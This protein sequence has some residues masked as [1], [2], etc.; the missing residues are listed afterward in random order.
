MKR[1]T[2]TRCGLSTL[3]LMAITLAAAACQ[4]SAPEAHD[5]PTASLE[6]PTEPQLTPSA[7]GDT[8]VV[9]T[10][11]LPTGSP[12]DVERFVTIPLESA[13]IG[14][15]G[16]ASVTSTSRDG[17]S[18]IEVVFESGVSPED[19]LPRVVERL[20]EAHSA[21][22]DHV[23]SPRVRADDSPR[24]IATIVVAG[25]DDLLTRT[26]RA[27]AVSRAIYT[28]PGVVRVEML[29][30]AEATTEVLLD[31][32]RLAA[33][34]LAPTAVVQR[35]E[36]LTS[37]ALG[38]SQGEPDT[39]DIGALTSLVLDERAVRLGDL[40]EISVTGTPVNATRW[41]GTSVVALD[42]FAR[43]GLP[44]G[45]LIDAIT[46]ATAGQELLPWTDSIPVVLD[47]RAADPA[48]QIEALLE[49][50][51][52][53]PR[54]GRLTVAS[55]P[56]RPGHGE[57]RLWGESPTGQLDLPFHGHRRAASERIVHLG[58]RSTI[59]GT[60][61]TASEQLT[62]LLEA[63]DA[64]SWV[65]TEAQQGA[66]DSQVRLQ[67]SRL[68]VASVPIG[69]AMA[70]LQMMRR[71]VVVGDIRVRVDTET[72]D[73]AQW[74]LSLETRAGEVVQLPLLSVANVQREFSP[75]VLQRVVSMPAVLI[76]VGLA[77][78]DDFGPVRAAIDGA[79]GEVTLPSGTTVEWLP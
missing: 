41:Q 43:P 9:V 17:V 57:V 78:Y 59:R 71:G 36:E 19:A 72:D 18:E 15:A 26:E 70:T 24:P 63:T 33:Y 52:E 28:V 73:L 3:V 7:D 25:D 13:L 20:I 10:T 12:I 69:D 4:K 67:R 64:V 39:T 61:K 11:D 58:V 48:H 32:A 29:G 37:T 49:D 50:S 16:L 68:A 1:D 30:G 40:A 5:E 47:V 74:V 77:E 54:E 46:E 75:A 38:N 34:G 66:L 14:V 35:I 31:P 8:T 42:V 45:P 51:T 23:G 44:L 79:I 76:S 62:A 65:C 21:L 60:A 56:G 53:I 22:P 6:Q 27:Q 55:S 2:Y